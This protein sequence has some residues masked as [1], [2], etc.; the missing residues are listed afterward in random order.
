MG[1]NSSYSCFFSSIVLGGKLEH[2]CTLNLRGDRIES[3]NQQASKEAHDFSGRI[4][5][6]AF[7]DLHTHGFRGFDTSHVDSRGL[8]QWAEEIMTT[9]VAGFVPTLVPSSLRE[10]HRFISTVGRLALSGTFPNNCADILGAR[11]EGPFIN[12]EKRGAL[13]P[14]RLMNPSV[15]NFTGLIGDVHEWDGILRIIDIAPELTGALKLIEYLKNKGIIVSLGHSNGT[16]LEAE[17]GVD[18]G[19]RLCTH[20]FN[21]MR[22]IHHREPGIASAILLDDRISAEIVNDPYHLSSEI[23]KLV[24]RIKRRD[25]IVAVTD[26]TS[27]TQMPDGPYS[28]GD[29][30]VVVKDGRSVIAGTDILAGSTITMDQVLRNFVK[31]GFNLVDSAR[32]CSSNPARVLGLKARG[33]IR[34]GYVADI[35]ILDNQY[36]VTGMI[37]RGKIHEIKT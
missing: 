29:M 15:E 32:F 14:S 34:P 18:A 5:V 17:L 8:N 26:S 11:L 13:D 21:G 22:E 37:R 12:P 28:L 33:A 10:T 6:P 27:L 19:A 4:A 9:G 31:Q 16:F 35:A 23:V 7:L 24:S 1:E 36:R 2:D 25:G 3:C 20:L 30:K